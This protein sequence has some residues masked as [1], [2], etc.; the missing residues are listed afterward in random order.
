MDGEA[1][2]GRAS[3]LLLL[4]MLISL[5]PDPPTGHAQ[6]PPRLTQLT[7][8]RVNRVL[9][10]SAWL[11]VSLP[12]GAQVKATEWSFAAGPSSAI[13]VAEFN[14]RGLERPD[15]SD[16]FQQRL[17]V[18]NATALGIRAL[19][20]D[21]SGK[22]SARV[23]LH[24]AVVEDYD[25]HLAVY[26]PVPAPRAHCQ[27]LG[28]TPEW[29]NVT[30]HCQAPS[31]AAVNVTWGTGNPPR[32]LRFEPHQLSVDGRSLR[33]ALPPSAW[34]ATY[35]CSISNPADQKSASFDLHATCL[36][37]DRDTSSSKPG[38]VVLTI[39]LLALSIGGAVWCWRFNKK[40]SAQATVTPPV[41][42][43]PSS[44]DPQYAEILRRSPPEGNDQALRH[45]DGTAERR[46]QKEALITTVYDRIHL[47]PANAAEVT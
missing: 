4:M 38:Y 36:R 22:Y 39:I 26:E 41:P 11:S 35:T 13:V 21:D 24:P 6:A 29:C 43:E 7:A 31:Q 8:R 27:L 19:Q 18:P 46:S 23:K 5:W 33:L 17:E 3:L 45:L 15:P 1:A 40:K 44:S 10:S 20:R 42:A 28:S 9:G 37:E 2:R 25:F 34:N 16:R 12:P 14:D 30:L 47:T 32:P